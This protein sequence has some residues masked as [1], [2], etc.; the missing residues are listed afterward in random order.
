M[1]LLL[2]DSAGNLHP[3]TLSGKSLPAPKSGGF[4][5]R[6]AYAATHVVLDPVRTARI[7][8]P[9]LDWDATLAFRRHLWSLGFGVAE[10]MDTA[11][12]GMGLDWPLALEL[13]Q[14][15]VAEA[16][17]CKGVIACGAGTDHLQPDAARRI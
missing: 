1:E 3:Y 5:S 17:A 15:S 4:K 12:R 10:A 11:Q 7:V 2:P 13:I 16:R 14:R 6:I 9:V 8:A